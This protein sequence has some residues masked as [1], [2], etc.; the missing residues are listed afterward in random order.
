MDLKTVRNELKL[1]KYKK[2][3]DLFNDIS[4]IWDNCMTYNTDG[5]QI[6]QMAQAMEVITQGAIIKYAD[7]LGFKVSPSKK[8]DIKW[9]SKNVGN[10]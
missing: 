1:G 2:F 5:S 8:R 4:L 10:E 7:Q 9:D 3:K 6:Y